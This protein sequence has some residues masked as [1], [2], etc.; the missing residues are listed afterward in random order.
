MIYY[1]TG[2]PNRDLKKDDISAALKTA[3]KFFSDRK[4]VLIIPPDITRAHS[5]AGLITGLL[6]QQLD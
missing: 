2:S 6:W 5:G 4:S 3:L 1:A